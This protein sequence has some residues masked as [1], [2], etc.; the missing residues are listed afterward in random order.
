MT[1]TNRLEAN[2]MDAY[3]AA[4]SGAAERAGP[5][6]VKVEIAGVPEQ[7]RRRR[8]RGGPAPE[9][10]GGFQAAGSGVIFDSHGRIIS[11]AHV[12]QAAPRPDAISVVLSDGR[13]L[14]AVV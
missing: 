1:M 12:V 13:R 11:N 3:S 5:A 4:V 8:G 9:A 2:A 10:P 14:P 7:Q 6:V